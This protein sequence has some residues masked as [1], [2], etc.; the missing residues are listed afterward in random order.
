M[1]QMRIL[2]V[3]GSPPW[4]LSGGVRLVLHHHLRELSDRHEIR[5][6]WLGGPDGERAAAELP[7]VGVRL[8]D[9]E[10]S[11]PLDHARRRLRS[12]VGGEPAHVHWV[13]RP[14]LLRVVEEE[15]RAHRP[16]VVHLF[17]WGTAALVRLVGT[18]PTVHVPID[19]WELGMRSRA[20]P[21]WRRPLEEGQL[22]KVVRHEAR[23]YPRCSAVVVV[24]PVDAEHLR[25]GVPEARVEVVPNGVHPGP[26][27]EDRSG[28]PVLGFHGAFETRPNLEAARLLAEEVL[29]AVR[30]RHP[31]A[32]VLI[33]GRDP[34]GVASRLA[35]DAVEVT[36]EVPEVRPWLERMAVYVAPLTLG[37]GIR[38]KLL[39]AMAAGVPVVSTPRGAD[40]IGAG[41]GLREAEGTG[42]LA[43]VAVDFLEDPRVAREEGLRGRERVVRDFSWTR[44]AGRIDALWCEVG[45]CDSPS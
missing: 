5:G 16:H 13:E 4:P 29:P 6:V 34:A 12:L 22:R 33:V 39:E 15:L 11:G 3:S 23:W 21:A 35:G 19:A 31:A 7:G 44:S 42:A 10:R 17:G 38:N 8:V 32:R 26:P 2:V 37:T 18:V 40:G 36:G 30:A 24:A 43:E 27:P 41:P 45:Y 20:L 1:R 9:R 25:A 14:G 28:G